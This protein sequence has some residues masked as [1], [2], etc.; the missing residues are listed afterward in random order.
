MCY[1][2]GVNR[3]GVDALDNEYCGHS[4]TYD[5]L[6][7]NISPLRSNKEHTEIVALERNHINFYRNKLKFLNDRDTFSLST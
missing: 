2:V 3:V 1:C 6:G 5:I 7:N 4:A